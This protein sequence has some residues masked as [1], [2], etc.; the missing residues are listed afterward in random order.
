MQKYTWKYGR[1]QAHPYTY[2]HD[3]HGILLIKPYHLLIHESQV[4]QDSMKSC[5][6]T[7]KG[8]QDDPTYVN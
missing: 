2:T 6:M 4:P 3:K 7:P 8:N 5:I 1:I